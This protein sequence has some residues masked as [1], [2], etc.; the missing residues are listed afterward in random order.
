MLCKWDGTI[1]TN[2]PGIAGGDGLN[3]SVSFDRG[4][5][6]LIT[7]EDQESDKDTMASG[8]LL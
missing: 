5:K 2:L 7:W 3:P 4:D 8:R 6:F 1:V